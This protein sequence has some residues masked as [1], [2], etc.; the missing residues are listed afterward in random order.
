MGDAVFVFWAHFQL[1]DASALIYPPQVTLCG[2]HGSVL[3]TQ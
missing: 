2:Q 3:S 1:Q